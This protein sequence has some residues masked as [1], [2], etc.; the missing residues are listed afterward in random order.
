M[1]TQEQG[2]GKPHPS[3]I[4]PAKLY[5]MQWQVSVPGADYDV[6]VDDIAFVGCP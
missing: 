4:N 3:H 5:A 6:W 2:W 1:A